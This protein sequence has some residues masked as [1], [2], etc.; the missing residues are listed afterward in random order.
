M[1]KSQPAIKG[2]TD[3]AMGRDAMN[4]V[5]MIGNDLKLDPGVA[6]VVKMDRVFLL[7]L[8]NLLYG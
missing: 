1:A 6:L 5:S 8:G 3:L 2:Y 4:R 7:V